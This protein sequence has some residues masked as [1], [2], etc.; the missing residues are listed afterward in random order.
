VGAAKNG[1]LLIIV[2]LDC[3]LINSLIASANGC[4]N[5]MIITLLGPL[6]S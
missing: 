1:L 6:R 2:G 3:S 5:P 4:G